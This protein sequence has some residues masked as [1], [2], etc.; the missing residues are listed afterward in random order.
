MVDIIWV[1]DHSQQSTM[2]LELN[3]SGCYT[4][5]F[6]PLGTKCT[7]PLKPFGARQ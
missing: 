2:T 4:S 5:K 3:I 7:V 6:V 1:V